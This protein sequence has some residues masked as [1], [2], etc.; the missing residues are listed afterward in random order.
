MADIQLQPNEKIL[1]QLQPEKA[2]VFQK[3]F[4]STIIIALLVLLI[5]GKSAGNSFET[6]KI[7]FIIPGALIALCILSYIYYSLL[8]TRVDYFITNQRCITNNS[9]ITS[10]RD[11]L[12]YSRVIDISIRQS[13]VEK[14]FGLGTVV[15]YTAGVNPKTASYIS[16]IK[17]SDAEKILAEINTHI[18]RT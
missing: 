6:P 15:L 18:S 13:I 8:R 9:F 4:H 11:I 2:W 1:F 12:L 10:N 17:F 3:L 14:I 16:G 7:I 5:L